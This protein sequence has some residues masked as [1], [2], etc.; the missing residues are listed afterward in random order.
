MDYHSSIG[1]DRLA[2]NACQN[3]K[4]KELRMIVDWNA[5]QDKVIAEYPHEIETTEDAIKVSV[6][7][8]EALDRE[9]G[10]LVA[11]EKRI[12]RTDADF[13]DGLCSGYLTYFHDLQG[14][15][16]SDLALFTLL[17]DCLMDG[18]YSR[19]FNAGWCTGLVEAI[20][21]DRDLFAR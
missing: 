21:E 5:V 17:Q 6:L 12:E 15:P 7:V 10:R 4:G 1:I 9:Y 16:L 14:K 11:L 18:R 20:I 13:T 19:L 8:Q 2:L 3:R